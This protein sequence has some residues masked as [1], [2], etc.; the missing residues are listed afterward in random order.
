M[1]QVCIK[2]NL[3]VIVLNRRQ[4]LIYKI[5][6]QTSVACQNFVFKI[7]VFLTLIMFYSNSVSKYLLFFFFLDLSNEELVRWTAVSSDIRVVGL[8][9]PT[10]VVTG[11]THEPSGHRDDWFARRRH[12]RLWWGTSPCQS[13]LQAYISGTGFS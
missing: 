1:K 4:A 9:E 7:K 12:Q 11:R 6:S 13:R 5:F 8:A 10:H 3:T 2:G